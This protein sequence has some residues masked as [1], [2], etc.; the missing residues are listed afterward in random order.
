MAVDYQKSAQVRQLL[1]ER[2]NADAYG[3]T[4]RVEAI[5][6][7]LAGLG[8]TKPEQAP[9]KVA[10]APQGRKAPAKSTTESTKADPETHRKST[11]K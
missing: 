4:T 3:Q 10:E 11:T 8:Y 5:D 6:K 7:Q 9:K 1:A 2:E